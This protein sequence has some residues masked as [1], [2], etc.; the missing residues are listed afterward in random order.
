[1]WSMDR[2]SLQDEIQVFASLAITFWLGVVVC[3]T[4]LQHGQTQASAVL[5]SSANITSHALPSHIEN[6]R[7]IH[8]LRYSARRVAELQ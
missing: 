8:Y 1:M 7:P 3:S 4:E 6:S 2:R 5:S